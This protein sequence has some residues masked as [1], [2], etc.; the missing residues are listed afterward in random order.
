MK[1]VVMTL[2]NDEVCVCGRCTRADGD[3]GGRAYKPMIDAIRDTWAAEEVEGVKCFYIYG[4]RAGI[5]FP[6]DAVWRDVDERSCFPDDDEKAVTRKR[7]PFAVGDCIYSDTPEGRE[8]LYYKTMDG[9][10]WLL[11]NEEFDY[12][13]R[14]CAGSYVHLS[15]FKAFLENYGIRDKFYAGSTGIYDNRHNHARDKTQP[16]M[17]K[18]ASGSSFIASRD[19]IQSIVDNRTTVELVRSPYEPGRCIGDDITFAK[20]FTDDL[21]APIVEFSKYSMTSP[22][23]ATSVVKAYMQAYYCH[24]INPEMHYAVHRAKGL[25]TRRNHE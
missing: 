14:P 24:T 18:F 22:S 6:E 23:Q 8:N 16:Q 15:M 10:E 12:L 2:A 20:Y 1:I 17:I 25:E 11:E 19:L 13:I 4:H 5:E 7:V 21:G 3:G 9:F